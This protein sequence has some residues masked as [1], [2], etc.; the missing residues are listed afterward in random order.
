MNRVIRDTRQRLFK[1]GK[2]SL[3]FMYVFVEI[4]LVVFGILIALQVDNWN[5]NRKERQEEVRVLEQLVEDFNTNKLI[6]SNTEREYKRVLQDIDAALRNTGPRAMVPPSAVFDSIDNLWTPTVELL[7]TNASAEYGLNL[8][9]ITNNQVKLAVMS[10]SATFNQYK[11]LENTLKNLTLQQR[12]IY[13]RY[14]P[15]IASEEDYQQEPFTADSLGF[16]RD[17]EFQN[18]S[19]DRLW[20]TRNATIRLEWLTEHNDTILKMLNTELLLHQSP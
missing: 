1:S 12:K 11:E 6:I 14:I 4:L 3:Y 15:L 17:R 10:Y 5:E 18:A 20:N 9:R 13:Q 2:L 19:V 16:L 7:H 8:D